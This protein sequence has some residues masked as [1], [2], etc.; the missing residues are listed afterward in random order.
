MDIELL[1]T[2][3]EVHKTRHFG[4]AA[5]NLH[6]TSAAVSARIK[7]LEQYLGVTL[8]VR[9]RGNIQLTSEGERLLPLADTVTL[10]WS[11]ALQEVAL[12]TS[13]SSRLHIGATSGLW[14]FS[15]QSKL[16]DLCDSLPDTAI[17][18][19]GHSGEELIRRLSDR[20]LDVVLLYE[21]PM[22]ADLRSDKIGQLKL[23]LASTQTDVPVR[24]AL[25]EGY[26][27]VDWGSAFAMFHA[28][29]FGEVP[30]SAVTVNL[31]SIALHYLARIPG[32]AY[33]PVTLLDD[34]PYLHPVKDAPP[35]NRPIYA[36]WRAGHDQPD[37]IA[38]VIECLDGLYV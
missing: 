9:N 30:P 12:E 38:R 1:K 23:I 33:L 4:Q 16:I 19:E 18:A 14:Q 28:K 13:R 2:F 35:F 3:L 27:Y 20:T 21:P 6:L 25:H 15:L 37:L 32:A 31:A 22:S 5:N 17:Q 11:R 26:V 10:T 8:F 7:Q 29:R 36:T 34:A 24:S